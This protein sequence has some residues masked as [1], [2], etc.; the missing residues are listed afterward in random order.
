VRYPP[1]LT[2][3]VS[4][5]VVVREQVVRANVQTKVHCYSNSQTGVLSYRM[6]SLVQQLPPT[7]RP[8]IDDYV[9]PPGAPRLQV[10]GGCRGGSQAGGGRGQSCSSMAVAS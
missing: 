10:G 3:Q 2:L 1:L 5:D 9:L 8:I 6:W 4:V 7:C